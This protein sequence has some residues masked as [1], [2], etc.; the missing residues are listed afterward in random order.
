MSNTSQ[1]KLFKCTLHFVCLILSKHHEYKYNYFDK[2]STF[3]WK[4]HISCSLCSIS[5]FKTPHAWKL[6]CFHSFWRT[7]WFSGS[8]NFCGRRIALHLPQLHFCSL[9][10]KEL[11]TIFT[12]IPIHSSCCIRLL[13]PTAVFKEHVFQNTSDP[14]IYLLLNPVVSSHFTWPTRG[15]CHRWSY[16]L[17]MKHLPTLTSR[18]PHTCVSFSLLFSILVLPHQSDLWKLERFS[19][20]P[21]ISLLCFH[22][23]PWWS[24]LV[25]WL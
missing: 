4:F 14:M 16:P 10:Q 3:W 8:Q 18:T 13:P 5:S 17:V 23:L 1:V 6:L 22:S 21:W 15:V 11:A 2:Y 19:L 7:L 12:V 25:S 20:C 24:H 9:E